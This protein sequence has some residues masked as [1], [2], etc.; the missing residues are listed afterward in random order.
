VMFPGSAG[1]FVVAQNWKRVLKLAQPTSLLLPA[2]AVVL[3]VATAVLSK[4]PTAEEQSA[5]ELK[6]IQRK[7]ERENKIWAALIG[8][9]ALSMLVLF[10]WLAMGAL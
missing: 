9:V 8:I 6:K 2:A 5:I 4:K 7:I 3:I 10:V 1:N